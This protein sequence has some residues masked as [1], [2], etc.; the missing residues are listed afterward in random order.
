MYVLNRVQAII[1]KKG[2]YLQC[3]LFLFNDIWQPYHSIICYCRSIIEKSESAE[4]RV[5][6]TESCSIDPCTF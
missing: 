1:D 3:A 5:S 6:E 2:S 4:Q